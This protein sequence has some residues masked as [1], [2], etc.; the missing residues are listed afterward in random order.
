MVLHLKNG[1]LFK[2]LNS[3]GISL[4]VFLIMSVTKLLALSSFSWS[5]IFVF[6]WI[7]VFCYL[8]ILVSNIY[9][10]KRLKK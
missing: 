6:L 8:A 5:F 2:W 4:S 10:D 3:M 9:H 1:W 7:E